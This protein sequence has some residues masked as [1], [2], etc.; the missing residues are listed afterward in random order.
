MP[1]LSVEEI[2]GFPSGGAPGKGGG[3]AV[4]WDPLLELLGLEGFRRALPGQVSGGMAQRVA[5]WGVPWP[6]TRT[7]C[8]WDEPFGSLDYFTRPGPLQGEIGELHRRTGKGPSS[9]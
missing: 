7:W 6:T 5:P 9:W 4:G 1:W 2:P 8:F 3:S